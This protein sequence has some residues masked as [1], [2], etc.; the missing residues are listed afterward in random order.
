MQT[1]SSAQQLAGNQESWAPASWC[2]RWLGMSSGL[3]LVSGFLLVMAGCGG[4][5]VC[6]GL[7]VMHR[8]AM[9]KQDLGLPL[10]P[11][12][13]QLQGHQP[14]GQHPPASALLHPTASKLSFADSPH[15]GARPGGEAPAFPSSSH[16]FR[17]FTAFCRTR[18][19]SYKLLWDP[20][21]AVL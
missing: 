16:V 12:A 4:E 1:G 10:I 6:Q 20:P 5:G 9:L 11:R 18:G 21:A 8:V 17:S 2:V 7:F 14:L 13:G 3:C 15:A 19:G